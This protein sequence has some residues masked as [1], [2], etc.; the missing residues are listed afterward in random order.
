MLRVAASLTTS[1]YLLSSKSYLAP[2]VWARVCEAG[3][4]RSPTCWGSASRSCGGGRRGCRWS[5]P[6]SPRCSRCPRCHWGNNWILDLYTKHCFIF[7]WTPWCLR[8]PWT[9]GGAAWPGWWPACPAPGSP[10]H[11]G[12]RHP[13]PGGTPPCR[14]NLTQDNSDV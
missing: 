5:A 8:P 10:P 9:G 3:W 2:E 4:G 12:W 7:T 1:F 13:C 6:S 11:P 14:P